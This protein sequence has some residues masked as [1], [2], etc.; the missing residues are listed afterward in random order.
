MAAAQVLP[1]NDYVG[2]NVNVEL[3]GVSSAVNG[4]VLAHDAESNVLLVEEQLQPDTKLPEH[5]RGEKANYH[6]ILTQN[7]ANIS[8][9]GDGNPAFLKLGTVNMER[10][11]N[12][13]AKRLAEHA[14]MLSRRGV[15][16]SE[17]AQNIFDALA[18]T[19]CQICVL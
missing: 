6:L 5:L 4:T 8:S 11:R 16:V 3:R 1:F 18:K 19:Y 13:E 17:D 14:E 2:K 10:I 9:V 15:G 12:A 7:I